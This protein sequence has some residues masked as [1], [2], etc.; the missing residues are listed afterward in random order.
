M[1]IDLTTN[2]LVQYKMNDNAEN[3]TV[4]DTSGNSNNGTFRLGGSP[5]Y[6]SLYSVAGKINTALSFDGL[7]Q[8]PGVAG[9]Y[10]SLTSGTTLSNKNY[11]ICF[12]VWVDDNANKP[13]NV[14]SKG[15]ATQSVIFV[16][17][18]TGVGSLSFINDAGGA[19]QTWT[20]LSDLYQTW[21][22][23]CLIS[24]NAGATLQ[25]FVDNT[26]ISAKTVDTD[27][28]I[29]YLSEETPIAA[30]TFK[31]YLDNICVIDTNISEAERNFLWNGGVGT[32]RLKH[33]AR[34]LVNGDLATGQLVGS[35]L[36]G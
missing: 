27:L 3:A 13:L 28:I 10:I 14:T 20:S 24:V 19:T 30:D 31:G 33:I 8:D 1:G 36:I 5:S 26:F 18:N 29:S 23:I 2:C 6:T 15:H 7:A 35:G 34:P 9:T 12:W 17:N 11:T 4:L 21:R 16:Q 25:L 22:W 32:E